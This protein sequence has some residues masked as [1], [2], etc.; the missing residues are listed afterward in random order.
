MPRKHKYST[1]KALAAA[2]KSGELS[3]EPLW[4]DNDCAFVYVNENPDDD[5]SGV[6]VFYSDPYQ[7]MCEALD[8]LGI[9]H[10]GV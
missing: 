10:E 1:L 8:L 4:L 7:I 6:A 2:Y 3:D 9:P 5:D